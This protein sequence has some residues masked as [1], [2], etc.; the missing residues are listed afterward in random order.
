MNTEDNNVALIFSIVKESLISQRDQRSSLETKASALSAFA[1]AMFALLF[2]ARQSLLIL[3]G[4]SLVFVY[5]SLA[6]FV[7]S[8]ILANAIT[9]VWKYRA[10]PDPVS[11]AEN[12]LGQTAEDTR[13]QLIANWI[14]AWKEN[15]A[16]IRR[17]A[18][19]LRLAMFTQ[20]VAFI[21]LGVALFL[22]MS[23]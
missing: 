14:D 5:V 16:Q 12:Y 15:H 7:L 1:G 22:S 4:T 10:D 3:T 19:Y 8:V 9:W 21:L 2:G 23:A 18:G 6:L 13:L 20:A 11:L 17:N